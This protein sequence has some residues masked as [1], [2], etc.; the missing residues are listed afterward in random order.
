MNETS[1]TSLETVQAKS[2][3]KTLILRQ[4]GRIS[5]DVEVPILVIVIGCLLLIARS[6]SIPLPDWMVL[7]EKQQRS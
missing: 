7:E 6:K 4:T 3:R 5:L 1:S 2:D